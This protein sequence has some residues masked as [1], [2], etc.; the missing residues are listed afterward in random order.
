MMII[1][2]DFHPGW[3]QV[4]WVDTETGETGEGPTKPRMLPCRVSFCCTVLME[5]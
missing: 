5:N 2:C 1:A 4:A 3:Q